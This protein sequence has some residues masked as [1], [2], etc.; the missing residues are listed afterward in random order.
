MSGNIRRSMSGVAI[1]AVLAVSAITGVAGAATRPGSKPVSGGTLT[2]GISFADPPTLDPIRATAGSNGTGVDRIFFV[3]GT[4]MKFNSYDGSIVPGLAESAT[5]SDGQTWTLKLRPNLRFSDGTP[6]DADAV[7]FNY[8][9]F[10]DPA[11]AFTAIALVSQ[12]QKMTKVDPRTVEFRLVQPNGSFGI[13]FTDIAGA[14]GSPTAIKA[15]PRNWGQKPIGAGPYLLKEWVRD[16]QSV[17]VRNPGY[18]DQP[19]PYIDTIVEKIIPNIN[20]LAEVMKSGQLDVVH[21]GNATILKAATDNAKTFKAWD[22]TKTNGS[23]GMICNLDKVPCNDARF[24]EALSLAF[25]FSSA[26]QVFLPTVDY[27][28]KRMTCP[29]WGL[30]SAFCAKDVKTNYDQV[31][32]KKLVDQVKA[33]GISTDLEYI[34]NADGVSGPGQGEWVQQ[35]LAKVGINV[36]VRSLTTNAYVVATTQRN[37]QAAIAYNQAALDMASRFYNDWHSAGGPGGGRDVANL[38]NAQLDV[39]LEKGRNSVQLADRI[40]GLQEAQRIMAKNFLVTWLYPFVGGNVYKRTL[41]LPDYVAPN[42]YLARYD[43]AWIS[44]TK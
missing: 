30:S 21:T 43:E 16:Q 29:P 2:I 42:S 44:P 40:A 24:R 33:D 39:A 27:P 6:L 28:A 32:A 23:I 7:I 12:I 22:T 31:R 34:F 25:D 4:L 15:D 35:Q 8:E 10:K 26:K 13:V 36:T 18:W 17:F 20:S 37:Y 38:N 19:R 14:M 5:T 9:R 41:H 1:A 11:N 3:F